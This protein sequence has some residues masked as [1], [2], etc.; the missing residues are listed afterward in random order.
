MAVVVLCE[1]LIGKLCVALVPDLFIEPAYGSLVLF[2][3]YIL[4]YLPSST[5]LTGA[6]AL[7][8]AK[9]VKSVLLRRIYL[10]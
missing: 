7:I 1:D 6:V 10:P 5:L 3:G 8:V 2:S 4:C 9:A